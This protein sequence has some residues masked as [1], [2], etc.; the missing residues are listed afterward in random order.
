VIKNKM[1]HLISQIKTKKQFQEAHKRQWNRIIEKAAD[2][3]QS[4]SMV[5]RASIN[6]LFD[7]EIIANC[8]GCY[9]ND[10]FSKNE[11]CL[12]EIL[13]SCKKGTGRCL[14]GLFMEA[15]RI[16]GKGTKKEKIE[17]AKKIRDFSIA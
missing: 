11:T 14:N 1:K 17:I 15:L 2:E 9:W 4:L 7:H 12:F 3:P 5:K 16:F 10:N 13:G 8:F 6:E